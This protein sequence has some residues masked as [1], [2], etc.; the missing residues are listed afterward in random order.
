TRATA[1]KGERILAARVDDI[2]AA[3]TNRWPD[4]GGPSI[5]HR[6]S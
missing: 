2:V 3:I 1:F 4:Q 5:P 6:T